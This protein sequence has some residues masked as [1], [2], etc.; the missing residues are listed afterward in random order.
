M[1]MKGNFDNTGKLVRFMLKREVIISAVWIVILVLFSVALAPGMSGMFD[2]AGRQQFA[3]SFDNP[4]MIAMMGP[5]YGA[6]NYT[7]GA[8]YAGMMLI[9]V[10]ITVGIMNIFLVV[11]HTRAD[12]EK[13]RAEVIRSL[14]VG[15]LSTLNATMITAVI[16]NVILGLL[17]GLG[18]AAT[19]VAN[20]GF[21]GSMLYG[22]VICVS[23]LVFAAIT[24]LFC[25]LSA[26]KSGAMGY[27]F[28]MLGV[29][30]MVRAA[31]DMRGMEILSCV[32]PLGLAQRTQA[33]V[34]NYWWPVFVLLLEFV[35]IAAVAYRLNAIRD[36][37]QGFI[38]ARPGKKEASPLLRSPF[39]LSFRLLRNTIFVWFILMFVMGASYGSVI[40]SINT[41]V[42]D[43]PEYLQIL[44]MPAALIETLSDAAKEEVVQTYF[45]SFVISMMTLLSI[46]PLLIAALKP[47]NEEKDHRA[48]QVLARVVPRRKYLAGYTALA[49][50]TS[51]LLPSAMA[52]GIYGSAAAL[53]GDAN[54]FTLGMLL[55]AN[56]VYLPAMWV[57]ISIAICLIGLLP[58][59]SGAIWGYFG[60]VCFASF[61]GEVIGLP[62]WLL[63]LAPLKHVSKVLLVDINYTPLIVMAAIAAVLTAVGFIFYRKR[64]MITA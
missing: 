7:E 10:I 24:A 15:R 35:G 29:F 46:V 17:T 40:P 32:S 52:V 39:G 64:D 28:L 55:K 38:P 60:F 50:A 37:D 18:I 43:S 11:R 47:R 21:A 5:V 49:Y 45:L 57:M 20:I 53:A 31:G 56:L 14:P 48:E 16:V 58:K 33:Y 30:Y 13:G 41:F 61:M 12:E 63:S 23:G 36:L 62:E 2:A 59:A 27:S 44:G 3:A 22:A 8:M 26:S 1:S 6:G 9:W 19:G 25:Q 34:G 42:G 54:P 4:V 51:L